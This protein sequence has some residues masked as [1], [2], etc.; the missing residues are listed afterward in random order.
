MAIGAGF[1]Q[2]DITPPAGTGKIGWIKHLAI[3]TVLDP[4]YARIAVFESGGESAAFVQLDTLSV[5]WTTT[6]RIRQMVEE[7]HGFP[8]ANVMVSATHNHAGPAVANCGEVQRDE[9]YID[10]LLDKIVQT[11]G[12]ALD[13][14]QDAEVGFGSCAEFGIGQNRRVVM[15]D[16]TVRTHGSF[17]DPDAL[18]L[19][20]PID[21]EVAVVAARGLDGTPLGVLV[22]Y[23]CHPAHHGG[24][25]EASAGFP[26]VLADTMRSVHWPVTLFLN[27]ACG[28]ISTAWPEDSSRNT[29]KEEAGELLASDALKIIAGMKFRRD[30]RLASRARTVSLPYRE[31]TDAEVEGTVRGAQRFI[32]PALY[33]RHIPAVVEGIRERGTQP[34]E[35]QALYVDE[36]VFVSI[37]AE[38]FVE[39]G[40]RIKEGAHPRHALVVSCANG[41][42]GY[43]PHK[44]AFARG[45]YETTFTGSSRMAPG[46]GEMLAE[47]AVELIRE[48]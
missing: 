32:D 38:Y 15:R 44:E 16:G 27:G 1:A 36:Y 18:Y 9:G 46:A 33:D 17:D 42:V 35:V 13:N 3:D 41:Q 4:L 19:E 39:L 6:Q 22:N 21:P 48:G 12:E 31:V 29:S 2:V 28:N 30:L 25:G 5:R 11:L 23:A 26:G 43:L 8:G 40:L 24:T 47:V 10:N 20:G 37:P 7:Q 14:R 45:G 34:A